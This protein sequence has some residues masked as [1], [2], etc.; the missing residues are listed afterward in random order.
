MGETNELQKTSLPSGDAVTL[1][2]EVGALPPQ[3]Y[4]NLDSTI[5]AAVLHFGPIIF[6]MLIL[7]HWRG[8]TKTKN[9]RTAAQAQQPTPDSNETA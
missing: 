6:F 7:L 8:M 2:S 5:G 4:L 1:T 3:W 9:L